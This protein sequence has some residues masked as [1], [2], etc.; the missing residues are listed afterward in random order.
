[1]SL[2]AGKKSL[3]R[4]ATPMIGGIVSSAIMELLIYPVNLC[5]VEE[6]RIEKA[7]QV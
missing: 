4:I 2:V 5:P 1:M 7:R 3:K 6:A